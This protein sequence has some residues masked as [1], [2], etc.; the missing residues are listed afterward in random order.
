MNCEEVENRD[1][2]RWYGIED[3]LQVTMVLMK[4]MKM[5]LPFGV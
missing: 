1:G 3:E 2:E 4:A 5:E